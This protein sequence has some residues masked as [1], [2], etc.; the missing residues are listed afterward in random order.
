VVPVFL[1]M[2]MEVLASQMQYEMQEFLKER[3]II[4]GY[5]SLVHITE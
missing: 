2:I 1:E 4:L 3:Y 5:P